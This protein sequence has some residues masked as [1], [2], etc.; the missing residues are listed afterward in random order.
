VRLADDGFLCGKRYLLMDRDTKFGAAFR[1][2]LS[3]AGTEPVRLLPDR[4]N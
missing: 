3:E 4:P 2:I 1:R